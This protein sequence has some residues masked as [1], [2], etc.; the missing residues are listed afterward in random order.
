MATKKILFLITKSN[1]GGAQ[2]YVYDLATSLNRNDY[3]P[4]VA[5]G[6]D[7]TLKEMLD[8][9]D[10][11]TIPIPG[12][13]RDFS[14]KKEI[15]ATFTVASII[16]KED[17][18]IFHVN[19][20]KAGGIGAFLGRILFV[21]R[22]IF[23]AHGWA[24]NEK[25]PYWQRVMIKCFHWLTIIF[26]H[27]T[28]A[29]STGL[30]KQLQWPGVHAK[31]IVINPGR[32]IQNMK[33]KTAARNQ[34]AGFVPQL[35]THREDVWLGTIAELH[36]IKRLDVALQ[37]MAKL[38]IRYPQ[39]RYTIVGS[40][41]L[42]E[43]LET[44]VSKLGLNDN[45]F[46]TGAVTEAGTLAKAFDIFMLPSASESYGYVLLEAGAASVPVIASNVGGIPDII[47][48]EKTGLLVEP[49]NEAALTQ[50]VSKL[51]EN[52]TLRKDLG[53]ALC[54]KVSLLSTSEMTAKTVAVYEEMSSRT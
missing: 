11:R 23:T 37:S 25:R 17:P 1:W 47:T 44:D 8:A 28:I 9:A 24:F 36:P 40:G 3:E 4:V 18:D 7:G 31:M 15:R 32:T 19:S 26:S 54:K 14:L 50:A 29:V 38:V 48:N 27:K 43:K 20:S 45:V 53:E 35:E 49:G 30:Q 34:L 6:G 39:L 33:E 2:R 42:R 51:I 46:F 12:L 52:P 41:E 21:P 13:Q 22:V 16:R 10:I 5:L